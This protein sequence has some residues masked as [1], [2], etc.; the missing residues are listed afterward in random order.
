MP[1]L[2]VFGPSRLKSITPARCEQFY[3]ALR[4][5]GSLHRAAKI[6][7]WFRHLMNRARKLGVVEY[8]PTEAVTVRHPKARQATWTEE[9]VRRAILTAWRERQY[10]VAVVLQLVYDTSLRP[11]DVRR[12]PPESF[13]D[14]RVTLLISKTDTPAQLPL[15]PET[16]KLIRRYKAQLGAVPMPGQPLIRSERGRPFSKDHLTRV[17]RQVLNKARIPSELQLRDLRRTASK[18]RAEAD[19]T[20]AE[21]A[22]GTTHSIGRGAAILDVYN[23]PSFKLAQSAQNK[24][25]ARKL[26]NKK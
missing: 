17:V 8:N 7:K 25:R 9:Q 3:D 11:G 10:G 23:P 26:K 6:F 13:S 20:A 12:L 5:Q 18:E 4:A 1:I 15:W 24:R 16:V 14:D 22:A 19:A 2:K 21:L